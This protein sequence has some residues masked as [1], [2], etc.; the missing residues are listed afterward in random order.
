MKE[1]VGIQIQRP[2]KVGNV[3]SRKCR[4]LTQHFPVMNMFGIE[5]AFIKNINTRK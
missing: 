2:V 5:V 1:A 4:H 3:M